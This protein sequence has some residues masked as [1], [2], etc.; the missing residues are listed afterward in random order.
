MSLLVYSVEDSSREGGT[1]GGFKTVLTTDP[2]WN[3]LLIRNEFAIIILDKQSDGLRI[4][5]ATRDIGEKARMAVEALQSASASV[6]SA[7]SSKRT[8]GLSDAQ[9]ELDK[10]WEAYRTAD[11]QTASSL[12]EK[13]KSLAE[14]STIPQPVSELSNPALAL[15]VTVASVFLVSAVFLLRRRS[16]MTKGQSQATSSKM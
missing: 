4:Y 7:Q 15:T 9:I 3:R 8:Q 16:H 6:Q 14:S 5:V 1:P 13:A 11:F 10:A 2:D 12:A